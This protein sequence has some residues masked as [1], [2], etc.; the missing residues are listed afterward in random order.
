MQNDPIFKPYT[1]SESSRE[2]SRYVAFKQ[3]KALVQAMKFTYETH[4]GDQH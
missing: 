1:S 4:G 2:E 3:I